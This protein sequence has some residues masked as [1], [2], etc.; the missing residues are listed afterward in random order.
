[1]S[2]T[3]QRDAHGGGRKQRRR[4]KNERLRQAVH[5][6][7]P[8]SKQGI[9]ERLFTLAFSGL[10]YSQIWEDPLVDL[11]ALSL[12]EDEHMIAIAS[13]GCNILSYLATC[14]I[15]I[16]AVD[17]NPSHVAL[18]KL[19]LAAIRHLLDYR[20]LHRFFAEANARDNVHAYENYIRPHLDETSRRYWESRDLLGRRR[21]GYF[22]TNLYRHGL[23]GN[24]IGASHLLVRLHGH[25]PRKV[26]GAK[27]LEEQRKIFESELAPLFE[28]RHI[29]WLL[30]QPSTLFGLGIPPSQFEALKGNEIHMSNV[31]RKRLER[32]ACGFDL[33]DNYFAWQAFGRSYATGR[34]GPLPPYLLRENFDN[35][36]S[37][38]GDVDVQHRS[39][40]ECLA[41]KQEASIDVYVL[42]DA[43]DWMTE[44]ILNDLW[45][46]IKRTARPGAR[47]IFRTA[48]EESILPGRVSDSILSKFTYD[49]GKCRALT[50]KDRS[51]IYGGFHLYTYK[52]AGAPA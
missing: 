7:K 45:G 17:L 16:T 30:N 46:E 32:L 1:M 39:F 29:R 12:K 33:S 3:K 50:A 23:L 13:G 9:Q 22:R 41:S 18:N 14:P 6:H 19:K 51:S 49:A 15:R 47:V 40:T 34:A 38:I 52:S 27:S 35:L 48:G 28:K 11:E 10:V 36:R 8:T 5:R 43:Q 42:L 2:S 44:E 4:S 20:A 21:I 25:D 37:R 26:L 31:V 24:L